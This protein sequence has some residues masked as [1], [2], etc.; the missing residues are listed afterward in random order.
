MPAKTGIQEDGALACDN[1]TWIP[2]LA[3][4]ARNDDLLAF[5]ILA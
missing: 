3:L 1:A 2:G 4:L 5:V